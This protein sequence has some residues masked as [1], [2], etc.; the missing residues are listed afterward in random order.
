M[1]MFATI[2]AGLGL[3]FIG[4][5]IIGGA[6]RQMTGRRF[7]ALVLR[8]TGSRLR[9]AALGTLAGALTQS[10]SA[11]TFIVVSLVTAG[12]VQPRR[13]LPLLAWAN[14]GTAALVLVAVLDIRLAVLLLIGV[15][16]MCYFFDADR[17]ARFRHVV[18]A[19]LGIGMLFLG[20]DFIKAGAAP[21]RDFELVRMAVALS[22]DT[23]L[24]GF[25]VGTALGMIAQ[26][27]ATVTVIAVAM[28]GV[29]VIGLEQ[30]VMLV[31]G[32]S[33]GSAASVWFLSSNLGGT[34][35]R[36]ALFQVAVKAAGL[37]VLVPLLLVEALGDLPLLV[38]A[39]GLVS[40]DAAR[41][42]SLFYLVL[43]LASVA[44]V[45]LFEA[46]LDRRLARLFPA[47]PDEALA[48]PRFIYDQALDEPETALVLVEREQARLLRHLPEHLDA[49]RADVVPGTAVDGAALHAGCAAVLGAVDRFLTDLL[50]RDPGRAALERVVEA[51]ASAGIVAAL[52]DSLAEFAGIVRGAPAVPRVA[53]LAGS[54]VE[55]LHVLLETLADAADGGDG[56][57][58][59]LLMA[60]AS[61]RSDL[62]DR[63]R[64]EMTREEEALPPEARQALFAATGVFERSV[65]LVRRY[66]LTLRETETD[67]PS[68]A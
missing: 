32:A 28:T 45:A 7:R 50:D 24:L 31:C 66:A 1:Q 33:L 23:L 48:T 29:G 41:Q 59:T 26:S 54:L 61:D 11:V 68:G 15:T 4:V 14:V 47:D 36:L 27:S 22:E 64:R 5:R 67:A 43:Q 6:F 62:M 55:A 56:H 53:A 9:A 2:F 65:W 40:D 39:L 25:M 10:T 60:L 17:S 8:S 20:L 46:P 44:T 57:D 51:Q 58:R 30:T 38:A 37:V 16:G 12:T 42:V 3:F 63:L 34:A 19:L 35:L 52:N 49:V 13:G 21:L 18:A